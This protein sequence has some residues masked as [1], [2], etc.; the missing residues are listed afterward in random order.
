MAATKAGETAKALRKE[1]QQAKQEA[2]HLFAKNPSAESVEGRIKNWAD[3]IKKLQVKP[4]LLLLLLL[5][6]LWCM[7]SPHGFIQHSVFLASP[8]RN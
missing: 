4:P 6:P 1:A 5:F 3:K 8:R 7:S 2:M